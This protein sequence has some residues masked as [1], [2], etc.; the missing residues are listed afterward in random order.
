MELLCS[1]SEV[2]KKDVDRTFF[3]IGAA[4]LICIMALQFLMR[5]DILFVSW[6]SKETSMLVRKRAQQ[7]DIAAY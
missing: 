1:K 2:K 3:A 4:N 7:S 5:V 6:H